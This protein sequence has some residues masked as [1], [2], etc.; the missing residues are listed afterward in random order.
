MNNQAIG[1]WDHLL[2]IAVVGGLPLYAW[3]SY[4]GACRRVARFGESARLREY[5]E[6]VGWQ[7]VWTVAAL[8]AWWHAG[9]PSS[10]L[11]FGPPSG[12]MTEVVGVAL[13]A[14][15]LVFLVWQRRQV[16]KGLVS[17]DGVAEQLANLGPLIPDTLREQRWFRAVAVGAGVSEEIVWRGFV[18]WYLGEQV[19]VWP[20]AIGVTALFTVAHA[21]Q[22][23]GHLPGILVASSLTM[24]LRLLTGGLWVPIL[25]H[26]ATDW[27]QGDV[28][29]LLRRQLA[30]TSIEFAPD[31]VRDDTPGG[32]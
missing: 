4:P 8:I 16:R 22:G 2:V 27:I 32:A 17:L 30:A 1:L 11:G 12:G 28:A 21:Y 10:D 15:I 29:R 31:T 24:A 23:L 3:F 25:L 5:R 20:A 6:A 18:F 14:A 13:G 7:I 26:A 9:R 19:G